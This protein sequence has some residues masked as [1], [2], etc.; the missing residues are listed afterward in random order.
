MITLNV[1]V[2]STRTS[3]FMKITVTIYIN[4]LNDNAPVFDRPNVTLSLSEA[5][6]VGTK[7][8]IDGARDRDLSLS[9]VIV[10]LAMRVPD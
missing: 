1:A 7:V 8:T 5:V 6:L 10:M 9:S 4:D 2:Q 3:F